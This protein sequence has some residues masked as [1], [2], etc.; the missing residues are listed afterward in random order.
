MAVVMGEFAGDR[1][2]SLVSEPNGLYMKRTPAKWLVLALQ[3]LVVALVLF[4]IGR[5]IARL[6]PQVREVEWRLS[7]VPLIAAALTGVL[8]QG[9]LATGWRLSLRLC[10][11]DISWIGAA[12][13]NALGQLGK[14]VPGKVLTLVGKAYLA[15]QHGVPGPRATVAMFIEV[16]SMVSTSLAVGSVYVVA[17]LPEERG[18]VPLAGLLVVASLATLHPALLPR[19]LNALFV[20][21]GREPVDLAYD[22]RTAAQLA[23]THVAFWLAVGLGLWILSEGLGLGVPWLPLTA[24]FAISWAAGFLS[25]I[26]PGGLGVREYALAR[27][28]GP[29]ATAGAA[30]GIALASRAWILAAE[31]ACAAI[32]WVYVGMQRARRSDD[33][34]EHGQVELD[35]E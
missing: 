24:A 15:S 14:Y 1:D 13:S 32:V 25:F 10:G 30:M 26:F 21:L 31:L 11:A 5:A 27:L 17:V 12:H 35:E 9:L 2:A 3:L 18:L 33:T 34:N 20:K 29:A 22:L 8:C 23:A 4:F 6:W 7:P 19:A 28:L 16:A